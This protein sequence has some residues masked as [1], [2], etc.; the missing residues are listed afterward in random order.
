MIIDAHVHLLRQDGYL[1]KLIETAADLGVEKVVLFSASP[2]SIFASNEEILT[3]HLKYPKTIIPFF[4]FLLGR[5]HPQ[6]IVQAQKDGFR[7]VKFINPTANYNDDAYFPVWERCEEL[8]MV[9]FFHTG[10]VAR[11]PEQ[12]NYDVDS[13]RMKVIYLDRI[14]RKFQKMTML[15]AHLGN[16]DYGEACMMCRWHSNMYFDLSGSTLKKKKPEFLREM[17]WW[18]QQKERYTD[19]YGRGPW[20]KIFFGTDVTPGEM[21]ETMEDYKRLFLELDLPRE[22]QEQIMGNTV[23]QLLGMK[24]S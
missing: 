8:G 14:A 16:P 15:V 18:G 4:L 13:S 20:D 7:G 23:A 6:R 9:T 5:D 24:D 17:L 19:E 22:T 21:S 11:T 12:V 3:A 1:E 10:I 2:D